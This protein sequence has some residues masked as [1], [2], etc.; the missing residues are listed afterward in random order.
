[1]RSFIAKGPATDFGVHL[2]LAWLAMGEERRSLL[3]V[4]A[5]RGGKIMAFA[6]GAAAMVPL[7]RAAGYLA[8][9]VPS[10]AIMIA[11]QRSFVAVSGRTHMASASA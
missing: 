4:A 7:V 8:F 11:A 10:F 6:I 1:M 5:L 9:L 2:A 3:R